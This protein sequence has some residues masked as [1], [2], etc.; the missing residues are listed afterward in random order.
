ME[1]DKKIIDVNVRN[2]TF[3]ISFISNWVIYQY[4]QRT[5]KLSSLQKLYSEL[6]LIPSKERIQEIADEIQELSKGVFENALEIIEEILNSNDIEFDRKW[7]ERRTDANDLNRF[8]AT[9]VFK[10]ISGHIKK[11]NT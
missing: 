10:D 3:K 8:L 6:E 1:I 7:W 5:K 2:K 11:K 9:C 4:E